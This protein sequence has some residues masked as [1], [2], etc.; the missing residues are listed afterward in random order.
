MAIIFITM[1]YLNILGKP[2]HVRYIQYQCS[3]CC[4]DV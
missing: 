1:V 2:Q 3:L 4:A